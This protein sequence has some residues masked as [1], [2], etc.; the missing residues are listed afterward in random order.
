VPSLDQISEIV[1][2]EEDLIDALKIE[3]FARQ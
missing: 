1:L 3:E 2:E